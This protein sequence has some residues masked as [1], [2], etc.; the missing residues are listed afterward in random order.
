LF[1]RIKLRSIRLSLALITG[2]GVDSQDLEKVSRQSIWADGFNKVGE[3]ESD[4]I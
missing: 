2:D 1:E 3:T 4:R